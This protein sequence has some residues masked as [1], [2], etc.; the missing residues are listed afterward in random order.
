VQRSIRFCLL[1]SLDLQQ[2]PGQAIH[3][4]LA[5]Q[6]R[7][8]LLAYLAIASPRR[9]HRRDVLVTL[10]WPES[11]DRPARDLLNTH[12]ARRPICVNRGV[13]MGESSREDIGAII[14]AWTAIDRAMEIARQ[15]VVRRQR[16]GDSAAHHMPAGRSGVSAAR[17]RAGRTCRPAHASDIMVDQIMAWDNA[18]FGDDLSAQRRRRTTR[19]WSRRPPVT[20]T[21]E[22]ARALPR[23]NSF[24]SAISMSA[25]AAL[26]NLP[27]CALT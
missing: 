25:L 14:R 20:V 22:A 9:F 3:S 2:A 10:F 24:D 13:P 26:T 21:R 15:R 7:T 6:R 17:S 18:G 27:L 23:Y 4:V 19:L 8:A 16:H 12:V 11:A 1:G 5:Q